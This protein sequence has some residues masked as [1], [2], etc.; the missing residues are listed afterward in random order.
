VERRGD[1]E[2]KSYSVPSG[3]V[4][5]TGPTG[6]VGITVPGEVGITGPGEVG[7]IGPGEVG[8]IGPGEVGITGQ[9][10]DG[11]SDSSNTSL[12]TNNNEKPLN[13]DNNTHS[14]DIQSNVIDPK[15]DGFHDRN[16]NENI[17]IFSKMGISF[18]IKSR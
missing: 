18:L 14:S 12:I 4:G 1:E 8:I 7:I 6:E 9:L 13:I 5:I 3:E 17:D 2:T 16:M 10:V 15:V 11:N